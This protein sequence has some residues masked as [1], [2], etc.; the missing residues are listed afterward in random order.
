MLT[1][2]G[3]GEGCQEQEPFLGSLRLATFIPPLAWAPSTPYP[4]IP[5][6]MCVPFAARKVR[7]LP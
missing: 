7:T 1:S 3:E 5:G 2:M 6:P 4:F